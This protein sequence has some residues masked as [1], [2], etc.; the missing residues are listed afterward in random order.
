MSYLSKKE[1]K[2]ISRLLTKKL[3]EMGVK[4]EITFTGTGVFK[5]FMK[6][7]GKGGV[8]ME[9]NPDTGK[10]EPKLFDVEMLQAM[11]V[12]RR[13]VRELRNSTPEVINA[14]LAMPVPDKAG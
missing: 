6:K 7:D 4:D 3:T 14:F 10:M 2:R 5:K 13:T 12:L 11:N 9:K 8:I 1:Q